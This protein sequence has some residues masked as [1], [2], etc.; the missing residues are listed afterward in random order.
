MFYTQDH[1]SAVAKNHFETQIAIANT[2]ALKTLES[3]EKLAS[4]NLAATRASL[5]E[6]TIA[7]KQILAAKDPQ[8]FFALINAQ[9]QPNTEKV[10]AYGRH[11]TKIVSE[12]QSELAQTASDQIA[13][14][15]RTV[16]ELAENAP[17]VI[18]K[19][20]TLPHTDTDPAES[21]YGTANKPPKQLVLQS[22]ETHAQPAVAPVSLSTAVP[23]APSTEK[24]IAS[25]IKK[26]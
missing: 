20:I 15:K 5:E 25:A 8:E 23:P 16:S 17:S 18:A 13:H 7:A 24:A 19:I 21:P 1:F 10:L 4:L 22:A 2:F 12:T 26:M 3:L 6:S 9:I 11:V 14:T